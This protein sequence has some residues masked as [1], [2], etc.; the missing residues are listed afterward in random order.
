MRS[1][2]RARVWAAIERKTGEV[3]LINSNLKD[4]KSDMGADRRYRLAVLREVL[5]RAGEKRNLKG[6]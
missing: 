4:L 5:H 2:K 3:W 6:R 1:K